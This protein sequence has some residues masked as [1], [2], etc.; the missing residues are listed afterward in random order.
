MTREYDSLTG[1]FN[2]TTF[3]RETRDMLDNNEEQE[4]LMLVVDIDRFKVINEMFSMEKGDMVLRRVAEVFAEFV[5]ERQG[6]Y[7]RIGSDRFVCCFSREF[8]D[9]REV[10]KHL[11]FVI[12]D[13]EK[14]YRAHMQVGIYVVTERNIDVI[15]MCDRA[16]MA[17]KGIKGHYNEKIAIYSENERYNLVETQQLISDMDASIANKDFKIVVQPVYRIK[18]NTMVSG[19][20]LVRWEHPRLG[21]LMPGRFIPVFE[22]NYVVT[23]LDKYVWEEACILIRR[24]MDSGEGVIPLSINVSRVDLLLE[25]VVDI[26]ENLVHKYDISHKYLRIEITE[27]AYMDNPDK[28]IDT[29]RDLKDQGFIVLMDDFGAGYS[30]LNT[31]KDL[32]FDV[33]KIDKKLI[34]EIDNSDKA[35]SVVISIIRMARW[36]GMKV[37]AEGIEKCSQANLLRTI[38]CDYLQG[39]LYSKP[40]DVETFLSKKGEIVKVANMQI[41]DLIN[42]DKIIATKDLYTRMF[43]E[44]LIGPLA[45]FELD[46]EEF[47]FIEANEEFS[48]KY[49]TDPVKIVGQMS[50]MNAEL[51]SRTYK[52]LVNKCQDAYRHHSTEYLTI[53]KQVNEYARKWIKIK[54]FYVGDR[55]N[56]QAF[57]FGITDVTRDVIQSNRKEAKELYPLLCNIFTE[58]LE[59]NYT[60]NTLTTMYKN[61]KT[62]QANHMSVPLDEMVDKLLNNMITPEYYDDIARYLSK[63][64]VKEYF[65]EDN[66]IFSFNV[67]MYDRERN[68]HPCEMTMIKR[69]TDASKLTILVC[70][71]VI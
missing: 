70:T 56:A 24:M 13:E 17:L 30:S 28:L 58:I 29:I 11:F 50:A 43:F 34:D 59:F 4:Y 66:K 65:I 19:E 38:G 6:T 60:E 51:Y 3:L 15:K 62:V 39:Y 41:K 20:V 67:D 21:L 47:R 40:V 49:E 18:D 33:L 27:S 16:L 52:K 57:V 36:L 12:K 53:C 54:I 42:L 2:F 25:D 68:V 10:L 5:S 35:G 37:V 63:E 32:S 48:R 9:E 55:D 1:I 71:R 26:L 69:E 23:K 31:L 44:E 8:Y 46:G 14:E 61:S 22:K 64:F 45:M 7:G